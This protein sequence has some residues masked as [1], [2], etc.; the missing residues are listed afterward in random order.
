MMLWGGFINWCYM[1]E[2]RGE[3]S[4]GVEL[5]GGAM[6]WSSRVDGALGWIAIGWSYWVELLGGATGWSFIVEL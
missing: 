5:W 1:V 6:G 3:L 4:Y 2:P